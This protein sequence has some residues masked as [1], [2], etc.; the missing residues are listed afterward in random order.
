MSR[1]FSLIFLPY[2]L[3]LQPDG[4]YAVLNRD[5]QPV[6]FMTGERLNYEDYPILVEIKGLTP[7]VAAKLSH[8]GKPDLDDIYFY[9]DLSNPK[10]NAVNL[11]KYL[12]RLSILAKLKVIPQEDSPHSGWADRRGPM[13][14]EVLN[15]DG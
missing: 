4:R 7:K 14:Q 1:E 9:D 6:G 11:K 5:Y 3:Q 15:A 8:N 2:C 10:L 13:P 12:D